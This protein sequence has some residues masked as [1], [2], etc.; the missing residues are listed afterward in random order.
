VTITARGK[1]T[2]RL[3]GRAVG[4]LKAGKYDVVVSDEDA[5]AGF[6]V[7]RGTHDAVPITSATFVGKK[8]RRLALAAGKWSFFARGGAPVVLTVVA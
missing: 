3:D 2:L 4:S 5:R 7:R 1:V 6:S 8:T